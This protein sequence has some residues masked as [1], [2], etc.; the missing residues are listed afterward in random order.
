MM[1]TFAEMLSMMTPAV[2]AG[3]AC[4][5]CGTEIRRGDRMI[6]CA[7]CAAI[8]CERCVGDGT[9]AMHSCEAYNFED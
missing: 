5:E 1:V 6:S 2:S 3:C 4:A 7:D 9:F 8:F